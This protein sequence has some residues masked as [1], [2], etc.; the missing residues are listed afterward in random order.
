MNKGANG[1]KADEGDHAGTGR[2]GYR[3]LQLRFRQISA[4][5]QIP[6]QPRDLRFRDLPPGYREELGD[7][8]GIS[9]PGGRISCG[10][11]GIIWERPVSAPGRTPLTE[12]GFD[13]PYPGCW[14]TGR[15]GYSRRSQRR[16]VFGPGGLGSSDQP[17]IAVQPA[18]HPGVKPAKAVWRVQTRS[19]LELEATATATRR[20]WRFTPAV[21]L[22]NCS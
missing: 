7:G 5:G 17:K 22:W 1:K 3:G 9:L 21:P 4:G 8:K 13:K 12:R 16:T 2:T 6:S 18:N 10:R 14:R 11:P 19:L 20:W 15:T